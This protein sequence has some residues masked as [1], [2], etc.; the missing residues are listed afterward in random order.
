MFYYY[1]D[2][3]G[4]IT[5]KIQTENGISGGMP[6]AYIES[7]LDVSWDQYK[8]NVETLQLELINK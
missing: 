8:V 2:Q 7:V 6:G 5:G 1:Y 4:N 3:Q